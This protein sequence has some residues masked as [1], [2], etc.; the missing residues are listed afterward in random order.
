MSV[1]MPPKPKFSKKFLIYLII[2]VGILVFLLLKDGPV[3]IEYIIDSFITL[4]VIFDVLPLAVYLFFFIPKC[5]DYHLAKTNFPKY[6][7]EQ[8]EL[9]RRKA[10]YNRQ[11]QIENE[12]KQKIIEQERQFAIASQQN[13][14]PWAIKYCTYPCPHCGHYKVRYAKWEDK[15]AS[16]AF[17][18]IHSSK[19]GTNYKCEH[20]GEMWE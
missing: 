3:M 17:W 15:K 6:V 18:G 5:M 8:E 7:K 16:V 12:R 19:L 20:C 10:E 2:S 1:T 9:Q 4:I 13:D 14:S 11:Q